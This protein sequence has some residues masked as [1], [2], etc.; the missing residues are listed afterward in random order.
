[1]SGQGPVGKG[2]QRHQAGGIVGLTPFLPTLGLLCLATILMSP[3]GKLGLQEA[4]GTL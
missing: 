4:G 2:T 1:M 3:I